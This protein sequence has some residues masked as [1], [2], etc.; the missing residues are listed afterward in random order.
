MSFSVS[1]VSLEALD[2]QVSPPFPGLRYTRL[3]IQHIENRPTGARV[4]LTLMGSSSSWIRFVSRGVSRCFLGE[5]I[6][7][8]SETSVVHWKA[9][10]G[11]K[12]TRV[13]TIISPFTYRLV[14]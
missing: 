14:F 1:R 11:S 13:L 2:K 3:N 4:G 7:Q 9:S 8:N 10:T 12:H 6:L 5:K